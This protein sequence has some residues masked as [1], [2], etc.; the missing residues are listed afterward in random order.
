MARRLARVADARGVARGRSK[1]ARDGGG[2]R[3][4]RGLVLFQEPIVGVDKALGKQRFECLVPHVATRRAS[5]H[6]LDHVE[7][8]GLG[9]LVAFGTVAVIHSKK[10]TSCIIG[11]WMSDDAAILIDRQ[12]TFMTDIRK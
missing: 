1:H 6:E 7:R 11:K 5:F 12:A 9:D 4:A 3:E 10:H 2:A 8:D